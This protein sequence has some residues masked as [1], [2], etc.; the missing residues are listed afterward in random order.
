MSDKE[1]V[2]DV[3]KLNNFFHESRFYLFVLLSMKSQA[4]IDSF[5]WLFPNN[6]T[7]F[8]FKIVIAIIVFVVVYYVAKFISQYAG[9]RIVE[10]SMNEKDQYVSKLAEISGDIIFYILMFIDILIFF[11]ILWF[12]MGFLVWWISFGIWF[13]LREILGNMIAWFLIL[14]NKKFKIGDI[15]QLQWGEDYFGKIDEITIRYTIIKTFDRRRVIIPNI[16]LV[17]NPVKTF[18]SEELIRIEMDLSIWL[19]SDLAQVCQL[20]KD[21]IN[22]HDYTVEKSSTQVAIKEVYESGF[23][24]ALYFYY[25]PQNGPSWF[26][27]KSDL[28]KELV[29]RANQNNIDLPYRH[30]AV[31]MDM[32]DTSLVDMVSTT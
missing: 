22:A 26:K 6:F 29:W 32:D 20:L 30:A 10:N 4:V 16:L 31:T 25:N 3:K 11:E 9:Q 17:N 27:I 19:K 1:S 5:V 12:E 13:A 15:I 28:R 24:L 18:S 14:T 23:N 8:V 21:F 7:I 2:D